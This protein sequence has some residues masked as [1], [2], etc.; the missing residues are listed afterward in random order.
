VRPEVLRCA[1][2]FSCS[3]GA[4]D[5]P[6]SKSEKPMELRAQFGVRFGRVGVIL[7]GERC[8]SPVFD[9]GTL[10]LRFFYGLT[11]NC[12]T[13]FSTTKVGNRANTFVF[14]LP[15]LFRSYLLCFVLLLPFFF[16]LHVKKKHVFRLRCIGLGDE[17]R[18]E[19][20]IRL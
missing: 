14:R 1:L 15:N 10:Q 20:E 6:M 16:L 11:F 19:S 7:R 17:K 9:G 5:L 12:A 18:H 8:P 2:K 13:F 4:R 3:H